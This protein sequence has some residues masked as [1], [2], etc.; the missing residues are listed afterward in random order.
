[1]QTKVFYPF[2]LSVLSIGFWLSAGYLLS[3]GGSNW[4]VPLA[5][6]AWFLIS[7]LLLAAM[8]LKHSKW[9]YVNLFVLAVIP[10]LPFVLARILSDGQSSLG[11][12]LIAVT[13]PVITVLATM[14]LYISLS[15][16]TRPD[17]GT[18]E[19]GASQTERKQSERAMMIPILSALTLVWGSSV[20]F[21]WGGGPGL[22]GFLRWLIALAIVL[23]S[24]SVLVWAT[25]SVRHNAWILAAL[26]ILALLFLP[27]SLFLRFSRPPGLELFSSQ[28]ASMLLLMYSI[29][30]VIVAMLI[31]SGLKLLGE[32]WRRG[33]SQVQG[34]RV[35]KTTLLAFALCS[36]LLARTLYNLYWFMIWDATT[37]PLG[38]FW[39]TIPIPVAL[40]AGTVLCIVLPGR[41]KL[42]GFLYSLLIIALMIAVSA[43][44][45]RV[46]FRQLTEERAERITQ[47]IEKYFVREGHYPQTL[48]Q[49]TPWYILSLREP[50]IMYGQNWC[51]QGGGDYYRL[52]Y[53]DREHWSSPIL[54]GHVYSA[55]GRSGLKEDICQQAID[56]FRTQNPDWDSVLQDYGKPTPTP[57]LGP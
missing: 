41:N 47:G 34:E 21:I 37:D 53:L 25:R 31:H 42:A 15:F 14:L 13:Y 22:F 32:W 7:S 46:D 52:G 24:F 39:M 36:L 12:W 48:Q 6:V 11:Y 54:F 29:A 57:D 19:A 18:V 5:L 9:I 50:V 4:P 2:I 56:A 55:Q 49:L 8:K 26:F 17:E 45:Q 51:Y 1:M 33:G 3:S 40:L 38:Y 23:A 10:L 28:H 16:N 35:G 43:R 27:D 44:A 30:L 20:M